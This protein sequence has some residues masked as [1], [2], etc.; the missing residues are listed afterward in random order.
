MAQWLRD[1]TNQVLPYLP[2]LTQDSALKDLIC[3]LINR[4]T[5]DVA[6]DPFANA[7]NEVC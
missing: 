2:F 5:A 7:F 6:I 1:S 4:Q 3:G